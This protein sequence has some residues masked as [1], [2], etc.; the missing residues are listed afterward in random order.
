VACPLPGRYPCRDVRLFL[1]A[2]VSGK[3]VGAGLRQAGHDVRAVDEERAL[4]GLSDAALLE[5]AARDSRVLVTCNV[6]DFVPLVVEWASLSRVHAGVLLV[7]NSVK[8]EEFGL[9]V[10]SIHRTLADGAPADWRNRVAWVQR[11]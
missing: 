3:R 4:E 7:P 2:H 5:L 11:A 1:D 9:L 10:A 8:H 6:R